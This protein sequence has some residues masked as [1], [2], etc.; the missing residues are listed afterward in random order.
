MADKILNLDLA[1]EPKM[2]PIIYGRVGDEDI[3]TVTVNV[4]NRDTPIDLTGFTITF[5]GVT[6]GGKSKVF[7]SAGVKDDA[8]QLKQGKFEYTFPNEAFS[9][10]GRYETAYFSFIKTNQRDST[11]DFNIIVSSN[12]DIDA[13][14]AETVIT[15]YNKLVEQ[16][17]KSTAEHMAEFEAT[18]EELQGKIVNFESLVI[19]YESRVES[20]A[21]EA[22]RIVNEAIENW[23]IGNFYT[24]PESDARFALRGEVG[25]S[26]TKA[27]IDEKLAPLKPVKLPNGQD[28]N[29]LK[30]NNG[31]YTAGVSG[32]VN[33]PN[34]NGYYYLEVVVV[35]SFPSGDNVV[36]QR[37]T[38][39][40]TNKFYLRTR[41]TGG[42]GWSTWVEK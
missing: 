16:L 14:E 10:S 39:L 2:T 5:E 25:D 8:A 1:K 38:E 34:P 9:V 13:E 7:D 19:G 29:A 17:Q 15:L 41:T 32:L 21:S 11:G 22:V 42:T 30:D 20:T 23:E 40:V 37:L 3:Q 31:V 24:K 35:L 36:L 6:A 12:A 33:A 18:F 28:L 26:Y 4:T 27:E